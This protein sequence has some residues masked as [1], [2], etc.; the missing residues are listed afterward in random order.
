MGAMQNDY[1]NQM[2]RNSGNY[3]Q[4]FNPATTSQNGWQSTANAYSLNGQ[5]GAGMPK[6]GFNT[7]EL[8][9]EPG[10]GEPP[11]GAPTAPTPTPDTH[12]GMNL[13]RPG[14]FISTPFRQT[15]GG[16]APPYDDLTAQTLDSFRMTENGAGRFGSN[17]AQRFNFA[18][19]SQ[20][21]PDNMG[22]GPAIPN[23]YN[24]RPPL[25]L[26]SPPPSMTGGMEPQPGSPPPQSGAPGPAAPAPGNQPNP[27]LQPGG[28]R[29]WQQI[30]ATN[31]NLAYQA[32]NHDPGLYQRLQ[33]GLA[34]QQG[35]QTQWNNWVKENSPLSSNASPI[36]KQDFDSLNIRPQE[37]AL[38]A[39]KSARARGQPVNPDYERW[40]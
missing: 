2:S 9:N 24:P 17:N 23:M 3:G 12:M 14:N 38:N 31:P 1:M 34:Q 4:S 33:G 28:G 19:G 20:W 8:G 30:A 27:G 36:S 6:S 13:W 18:G 40:M 7:K 25:G 22:Y 29:T 15:F 35:G 10:M 21:R 37:W 5:G 26:N 11:T 16:Q 32:L 39:Y